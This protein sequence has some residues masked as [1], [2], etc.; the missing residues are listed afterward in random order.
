MNARNP[1]RAFQE[2]DSASLSYYYIF[3][4]GPG[5]MTA[6]HIAQRVMLWTMFKG[7]EGV[8]IHSSSSIR[9]ASLILAVRGDQA[10]REIR[11]TLLQGW[12]CMKISPESLPTLRSKPDYRPS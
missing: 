6:E 2:A 5:H 4:A 1:K 3:C 11:A 10:V 9:S 8:G 7:I 12:K